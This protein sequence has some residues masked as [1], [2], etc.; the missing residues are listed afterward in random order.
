MPWTEVFWLGGVLPRFLRLRVHVTDIMGL[1]DIRTFF[2]LIFWLINQ[3]CNVGGA[4]CQ[5]LLKQP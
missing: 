5:E 1:F 3:I 2:V 4:V